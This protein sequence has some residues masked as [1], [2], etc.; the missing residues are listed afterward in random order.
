MENQ[1]IILNTLKNT[2]Q[3]TDIFQNGLGNMVLKNQS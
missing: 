3:T 2:I 1:K